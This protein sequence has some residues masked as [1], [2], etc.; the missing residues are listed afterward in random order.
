MRLVR[1]LAALTAWLTLRPGL[2]SCRPHVH[3]EASP[4]AEG[5][6]LDWGRDA[7]LATNFGSIPNETQLQF[8]SSPRLELVEAGA[9]PARPVFSI[10]LR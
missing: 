5:A 4:P 3:R 10:P 2:R 6:Q 7:L 9:F 1:T 8:R